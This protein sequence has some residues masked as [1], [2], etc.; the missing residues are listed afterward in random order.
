MLLNR[1]GDCDAAEIRN[2]A[3]Q[4]CKYGILTTSVLFLNEGATLAFHHSA[5]IVSHPASTD[6]RS[7]GAKPGRERQSTAPKCFHSTDLYN[8]ATF[9]LPCG[10]Y[11]LVFTPNSVD[12]QYIFKKVERR[13]DTDNS[14]L[15][16]TDVACC[17][18]LMDYSCRIHRSLLLDFYRH[19]LP[20][21]LWFRRYLH[22][23]NVSSQHL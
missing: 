1:F 17:T 16:L 2:L 4:T 15:L 18:F 23:T 5:E 19:R 3:L 12:K 8:Q 6:E 9:L 13:N 11:L 20:P 10:G 14:G 21:G 7:L 22:S